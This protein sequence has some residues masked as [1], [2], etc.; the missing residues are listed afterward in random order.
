[1][2]YLV[3]NYS[4]NPANSMKR[5]VLCFLVA[6][7]IGAGGTGCKKQ[8]D[9]IKSDALTDYLAANKWAVQQYTEGTTDVT[10]EFENYEFIFAKNNTVTGAQTGTTITYSGTWSSNVSAVTMT[11]QFATG[12]PRPVS[13]LNGTWGVSSYNST[14]TTFSQTING[15]DMKLILRKK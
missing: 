8:I 13:L 5:V 3:G 9:Q 14:A 2:T 12:T 7:F 15:V 1:M 4:Q 10:A 6:L 11:A